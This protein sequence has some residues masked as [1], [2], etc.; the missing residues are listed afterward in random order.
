M[1]LFGEWLTV[2]SGLKQDWK[3]GTEIHDKG[4]RMRMLA[5]FVGDL[6]SIFYSLSVDFFI[7]AIIPRPLTFTCKQSQ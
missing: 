7:V 1:F 5:N 2:H 6:G 4:S 3:S